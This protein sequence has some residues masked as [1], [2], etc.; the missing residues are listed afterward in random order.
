MATALTR[1]RLLSATRLCLLTRCVA[2][3]VWRAQSSILHM[4]EYDLTEWEFDTLTLHE[5]TGGHALQALGWA[6]AKRHGFT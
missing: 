3:C 1:A 5:L 6:L 2:V 4:L